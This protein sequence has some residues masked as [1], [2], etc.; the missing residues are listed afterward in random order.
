V[1]NRYF[2]L[3]VFTRR[4]AI[5]YKRNIEALSIVAVEVQCVTYA[6]RVSVALVI[7]H[8]KRVRRI[9]LSSVACLTLPYFSTLPQKG[10]S[11]Q[12]KIIENKMCLDFLYK[13]ILKYFSF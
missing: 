4:Q 12:E 5:Y 11:F 2:D 10:Q 6:K 7:Q 1:F 3:L 8:A 13:F 9:I